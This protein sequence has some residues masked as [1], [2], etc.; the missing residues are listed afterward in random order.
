[1]ALNVRFP[2]FNSVT[3]AMVGAMT[4]G[5]SKGK[6]LASLT[7]DEC[8]RETAPQSVACAKLAFF[9]LCDAFLRASHTGGGGPEGFTCFQPKSIQNG[10]CEG[11]TPAALSCAVGSG[12][13]F[14]SF[15]QGV[16]SMSTFEEGEE[17]SLSDS[18]VILTESPEKKDEGIEVPPTPK[19]NVYTGMLLAAFLGTGLAG[20]MMYREFGTYDYKKEADNVKPL[21][22]EQV[23]IPELPPIPPPPVGT[24]RAPDPDAPG[25]GS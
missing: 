5:E 10:T 25:A 2:T 21:T 19:F 8:T 3:P 6:R 12:G 18:S 11:P 23:A 14:P 17:L 16:P 7:S 1:M 15:P 4:P 13:R 24:P 22:P 9:P 20:F